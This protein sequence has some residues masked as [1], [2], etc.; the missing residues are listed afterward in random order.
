MQ[1]DAFFVNLE[2]QLERLAD[3]KSLHGEEGLKLIEDYRSAL[4]EMLFEMNEQPVSDS[5]EHL[6]YKPLNM[7]E[8]L[9]FISAN[10]FH[11]MRYQQMK[12][13][14]EEIKK[15]AAVKKIRD[16]RKK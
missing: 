7:A 10:N 3:T 5:V 9:E 1:N 12:T 16:S 6:T 8:R 11:F 13:L 14:R 15:L 2:E 4:V